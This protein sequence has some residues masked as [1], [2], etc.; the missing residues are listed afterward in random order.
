MN[1][2]NRMSMLSALAL[3]ATVACSAGAQSAERNDRPERPRGA[4]QDSTGRRGPRGPERM[5]LR[6]ITL[7]AEQQTRL[8]DLQRRERAAWEANRPQRANGQNGQD[9]AT[10]RP[11]RERGDTTGLAARS[12]EMERRFEQRVVAIREILTQEQRTQFDM[13][14]AEAKANRPQG[15]GRFGRRA[16][17]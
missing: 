17:A 2:M 8:A 13:N 12:A 9:G 3:A 6:G 10:A 7:S 5:L 16:G 4:Q 14:V 1:M 11:R 15:E